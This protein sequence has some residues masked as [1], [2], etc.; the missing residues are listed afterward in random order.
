MSEVRVL[1]ADLLRVL[2]GH[3]VT[4]DDD[5]TLRL[6]TAAEFLEVQNAAA[7]RYGGQRIDMAKA[8]DL[9][10]PLPTKATR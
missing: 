10:R 2:T 5:V 8:V 9:T 6:F 1:P 4:V 3:P 7:D